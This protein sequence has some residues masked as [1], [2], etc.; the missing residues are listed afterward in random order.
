M[1]Y[2]NDSDWIVAESQPKY[3]NDFLSDPDLPY[4][5]IGLCMEVHRIL[6]HGF[7]EILYKDALE[8]EFGKTAIAFE[9]EKKYSVPYKDIILPRHYIADFSVNGELILEVKAQQGVIDAHYAQ[10]INYLAVSKCK[11]G[12][13]VN[14]AET[15]L[16]Y[17]RVIL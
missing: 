17:K 5:V 15:S 3:S 16:V 10:V 11:L 6:G 9:R 13:L 14:F 8:Y 1:E 12:L 4:R 7:L 2:M